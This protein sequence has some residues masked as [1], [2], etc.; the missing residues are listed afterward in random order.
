M[1]I[2]H[3]LAN[4]VPKLHQV[5]SVMVQVQ[6]GIPGGRRTHRLSF[7]PAYGITASAGLD[8]ALSTLLEFTA[9]VT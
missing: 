1:Q 7:N 8:C 9:V 4:R 3:R 2:G 6:R 5:A